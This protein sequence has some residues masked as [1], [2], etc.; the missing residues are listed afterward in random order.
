VSDFC[1]EKYFTGTVVNV[2]RK[3]TTART[4]Q[5]LEPESPPPPRARNFRPSLKRADTSGTI[6]RFRGKAN[7]IEPYSVS[8]S[9]VNQEEGGCSDQLVVSADNFLICT[10]AR[11]ESLAKFDLD[12]QFIISPSA[13]LELETWLV[14]GRGQTSHLKTGMPRN[15]SESAMLHSVFISRQPF[16]I[17]SSFFLPS[18][19]ICDP[20]LA[21]SL[22]FPLRMPT[23]VLITAF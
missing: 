4:C 3:M 20:F 8:V 14:H 16:L 12:G 5:I 23:R 13:L 21:L 7:F 19:F 17:S 10:G 1:Q 11:Y 9:P 18:P 6:E 2:H 22:P 15:R